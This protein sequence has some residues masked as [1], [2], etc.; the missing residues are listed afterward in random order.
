MV[1]RVP[2]P[3]V[4]GLRLVAPSRDSFARSGLL[5][6]AGGRFGCESLVTQVS[7]DAVAA[8]DGVA[9]APGASVAAAWGATLLQ[10]L[11]H[12]VTSAGFDVVSAD[13]IHAVSV[14]A[15]AD[16]AAGA[17]AKAVA[18]ALGAPAV[19]H[20]T[21][22]PVGPAAVYVALDAG[23][24]A[25]AAAAAAAPTAD[26]I[27]VAHGSAQGTCLALLATPA[28]HV[29]GSARMQLAQ[30]AAALARVV[31]EPH[32][33]FSP[34][35][36]PLEQRSLTNPQ[37][38]FLDTD[39]ADGHASERLED[40]F[41]R[42][43]HTIPDAVA[44]ECCTNLDGPTVVSW[45]YRELAKR[46]DAVCA[47]ISP[48]LTP[49]ADGDTVVALCM[50]KCM[51]MYAA[52]LGVLRAGATWCP[53]DTQWPAQRQAAL[54][55]KAGACAVLVSSADDVAGVAPEGVAVVP[56]DTTT[57]GRV[58]PSRAPPSAL[59]Y[60]IWTSGTTGLP[61]A[62]GI[63][64]T[65]AVQ[66]MRALQA[67][68]PHDG[69]TAPGALRF[70]QFAAYVFDL[71]IFD[72]FYAWGHSGTVCFAPAD[73]MI[74]QLERVAR[75]M[76]VTHTL[77]TPAVSAMVRRRAVP[78]MRVLIN[79]GE[80]LSQVVADEWTQACRLVNIYGPA[81]AT[82]SL[83]MRELPPDDEVKSHNIG[84]TFETALTA[85]VDEHG[86]V[87]ARGC[88]GE[89]L[90]GGP[91]LARGYIGDA[92]K[93]ADKFFVHDTLGR[94]YRTGDLA[95][96][97]WDGQ[98]EYLGR[99]DDQVKINGVRIEL[100]EINAAVKSVCA[101]VRDAD[102][103][104]LH[105]GDALRIVSFV[106][107]PGGTSLLRDDDE[108]AAVAREVRLGA[109][110]LLPSY[111][112]PGHICV[113]RAFPRT[114][115]AKID[116]RAVRAAFDALD[117]VAWE[118]RVAGDSDSGS[119]ALET[120]LGQAARREISTLLGIPAERIGA[121]VP[122]PAL[123]LNSIRAMR[124]SAALAAAGFTVSAADIVRHE[125]LAAIVDAAEHADE[126]AASRAAQLSARIAA[127]QAAHAAAVAAVVP[128]AAVL[129]ATPLQQSML[130]ETAL[131]SGRYWL[132]R[133]LELTGEPAVPLSDALTALCDAI[134]TLRTGFVGVDS[135]SDGGVDGAFGE[136]YVAAVWPS[137]SPPVIETTDAPEHAF[138]TLRPRLE[139][140]SGTP[141]F[142]ALHGPDYIAL[143][144]HHALYDAQSLDAIVARLDQ[145]LAGGA[146]DA[147]PPFSGALAAAM[148]LDAAAERETRAVW[149]TQLATYPKAHHIAFPVL[150]DDVH[151]GAASYERLSRAAS[152]PWE[153]VEAAAARLGTSVR[154]LAQLA[155]AR[156]L[157]AYM[158]TDAV[159]L[160]DV[161]SQRNRDAALDH[162]C[163]PLLATLAVPVDLRDNAP[164]GEA[165][166]RLASFHA[167][168]H[169]HA[170]VPLSH[171]RHVA[172][173]P[174][175]RPL[176]EALF[177]LE[178]DADAAPARS[179]LGRHSDHGVS[180]EHA[181]AL[182][183]RI[184]RGTLV[185][186]LNWHPSLVSHE[187]AD[188]VL[189][190]FDALLGAYVADSDTRVMAPLLPDA[191]LAE[192]ARVPAP[193]LRFVNVADWVAHWAASRPDDVALEVLDDV[194]PSHVDTLTY[195]QLEAASAAVAAALSARF[196]P[197]SVVAVDVA[198]STATYI[199]LVGVLR[200]G[201]VYLPLDESLPAARKQ[202]LVADSGAVCILSS[203][204]SSGTPP[205]LDIAALQAGGGGGSSSASSSASSSSVSVAPSDPAY[206]LYTSGS[207]GTPK[208]C[209]L[210]H[211]NLA[212]AIRNLHDALDAAAPGSFAGARYLARSAE[213]F[214]VHLAEAFI[215]IYAGA[216]VVTMPRVA[217]LADMAAAIRAARATHACVVPS[218]FFTNGRRI[219]P[220]DVPTLRALTIGG[221]KLPP[222][223]SALWADGPPMLNA[224]GPTEAAIGISTVRVHAGSRTSVIGRAFAGNQYIVL[225]DGRSRLAL[226][227]EPGELCI[228]GTHVGAGYV[229]RASDA[230]F[231]WRG[232]AAYATGDRARL[233]PSDSAEYL[234]RLGASQVKVRGARV[235]LDEIDAAARNASGLHVA[236]VLATHATHADARLVTFVARTALAAADV[237]Y[238]PALEAAARALHDALRSS[239]SS[240]MVPSAVIPVTN[241][242][243]AGVSAKTDRRA[244][245]A[246]YAHITPPVVEGPPP[247]TAAELALAEIVASVLPA[248]AHAKLD[249]DLGSAGLDSLAAVRIARALQRIG[250]AVAP[251]EVLA[252]P[253]LRG[254]GGA[255]VG[256]SGPSAA[257]AAA[258]SDA[259]LAR[260]EC[261]S[262]ARAAWP[263]VPL[264]AA[265]VAAALAS[266]SERLYVNH[267]RIPLGADADAT[268]AA[269]VAAL[270]RHDIYATVFRELDGRTVQVAVDAQIAATRVH[271]E[272]T[273]EARGATADDIIATLSTTPPVRVVQYDD[274]L[275][276]SIHHALYDAVSFAELA[277]L[278][279]PA[280]VQTPE[281]AP[282]YAQFALHV[283]ESLQASTS[284][285]ASELH[286][287][288]FVPF[289][290]VTGRLDRRAGGSM[291]EATHA[292]PLGAL[293][294]A[295]RAQR[296]TLH[297]AA[298][299][300]AAAV[301]QQY[302]GEPSPIGVV[303]S[304]RLLPD[305]ALG[306]V[307][308]PCVTTVP[309]S[310]VDGT[311]ADTAAWLT[312]ALR[313]QF[314]DIPAV[315]RTLER[316]GPLFDVLFSFQ[317]VH[318][319]SDLADEMRT[320]EPLAIEVAPSHDTL[321]VRVVAADDRLSAVQ[322]SLLARQVAAELERMLLDK[323]P[324]R[325]LLALAHVPPA[326]PSSDDAFLAQL[327]ARAAETPDAPALVFASSLAPLEQTTLTYAELERQSDDYARRLAT[328]PGR[329]LFV[330]LP[331]SLEFYITVVATWKARKIY[332]PLDPTL[333]AERLAYMIEVVAATNECA[334]LTAGSPPQFTGTT[335][336]LDALLASAP[337]D[338]LPAARDLALPA[339][340]L[341]TS[342]STGKPKGVQISQRA[343]AAALVS[344]REM[345]PFTPHSRI[346]QLASPG[347][348]VSLIELCMPLAFGYSM[349]SA[350][351]H[352]ILE[353][354]EHALRALRISVT[355]LPAALVSLVH[356][357]NVPPLEWILSGGD[358]ID[359]RVLQTW[360][361]KPNTLINAYG[362]TES[363]IGN[364][365]G[366]VDRD[367]RRSVVGKLYPTSSLYVL[368]IGSDVPVYAGAVGELV[369]GGPQVGD[370]YVGAPE[371]SDAKFPTLADGARVYRTGD[372]GRLLADGNIECL[373]RTERG[374]VKINGQRVELDEIAAELASE[375][376]VADA[377]VLYIQHP[378]LPTRQLVAYIA[379]A[380]TAPPAHGE[381]LQLRTD[382]EAR[383]AGAAA[384]HGAGARLAAYMIPA[385]TLVLD[386]ALPLTPNN[387][388]DITRLSAHFC[389]LEQSELR[390]L[391][392]SVEDDS[393]VGPRERVILDVLARFTGT[394][395][396][397]DDLFYTLGVDSL[398]AI[399]LVRELHAAGVPTSVNVLLERGTARRLAGTQ[400]DQ[401]TPRAYDEL[402]AYAKEHVY[403]PVRM[404]AGDVEVL[405]CTPLQEGMLAR[406][407]ASGGTEYMYR[408]A[409]HADAE[410]GAVAAAWRTLVAQNAILRTSF[411]FVDD[412]RVP[413][414]QAVH[415]DIEPDVHIVA[416]DE[417]ARAADKWLDDAVDRLA[418]P[419]H[420]LFLA[421]TSSTDMVL[422][423]HHALYDAHALGELLD[424]LDALL[425]HKEIAP[426]PPFATLLPSLVADDEAAAYWRT[427]LE[428]FVP[429]PLAR[430]ASD[431]RGVSASLTADVDIGTVVAACQRLGVSM[432]TL[433]TLAY[434][435]LLS[436]LTGSADV[437]F[438]Q[439]VSLRG[440][441]VGGERVLGPAINT[442]AT[443]V[444][445]G[446]AGAAQLAALQQATDGARQF[447]HA[448]L[449]A[450]R[451][452]AFDAL[453]DV[454]HIDADVQWNKLKLAADASDDA[455]V[456]YALNVAFVQRPDSLV[457]NGTALASFASAERLHAL[458]HRLSRI[459]EEIVTR[460]DQAYG[461]ADATEISAPTPQKSS[462][463]GKPSEP[464][465][466][467]QLETAQRV[468]EI[469][470]QVLALQ[471]A[472]DVHTPL[473]SVGL[474]SI[475]AIRV[476]M[477]ARALGL[478][479]QVHH[480]AASASAASVARALARRNTGGSPSSTGTVTQG[481]KAAAAAALGIAESQIE[482]V[483]ALTA[484]QA[485]QLALTTFSHGR[486]GTFSFA[487]R[488][489]SPD[490]DRLGA[491]WEWLQQRHELLRSVFAVVD[492]DGVQVV[493][494]GTMPLLTAETTDSVESAMN[495]TITARL[496]A[497]LQRPVAFADL[498]RGADGAV[499]LLSLHHCMYDAWS[500]PL[501]ISDLV[502]RYNGEDSGVFT[503]I[504]PVLVK[505]TAPQEL[506]REHWQS[507]AQAGACLLASNA[508]GA[509]DTFVQ[510]STPAANVE[511]AAKA[512]GVSVPEY[513]MAA[514]AHTLAARTQNNTPTFGVFHHGRNVAIDNV[515]QLAAPCLNLLPLAVGV[516]ASTADTAQS[517]R[518][519]LA[520]R[521]QL[522]QV[523]IAQVHE[524]LGLGQEPRFNT[525]L[526]IVLGQNSTEQSALDQVV[527]AGL[528]LLDEREQREIPA[529]W[530]D[531]AHCTCL[532]ESNVA[533][534]VRVESDT[535]ALALRCNENMLGK[536]EAAS[537][538]AEFAYAL[539]H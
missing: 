172:A 371:L 438:G 48:I 505:A 58:A 135:A 525:H 373:G 485:V 125:T 3:D 511:H 50:P 65:A 201:M 47:Q 311:A 97:L 40:Q 20:G 466:P 258:W 514:W 242:P 353:D 481:D 291:V 537:L 449:R 462:E 256:E 124:L 45:T 272:C 415:A 75:T 527:D 328:L 122:L 245:D 402:V 252:R 281:A 445:V 332:V 347:F 375:P 469:V 427:T 8:A 35:M 508:S 77:L 178:V 208:G 474:D 155:W 56:V 284:F 95:R 264:Q 102:T 143:C 86:R 317:P 494:R 39:T 133:A 44:L 536:Y 115:S 154:P 37:P 116:R 192:A 71:S 376:G 367:T 273:V 419:P 73:I 162:V 435:V 531:W 533:V 112:V 205:T 248:A 152:T 301:V 118:S 538:L 60:K 428:G 333:P 111:M 365:L 120:P 156:L 134:E 51:D 72:I 422:C 506:V 377:A 219:A 68:V 141:P 90:L 146:A 346:L 163:G 341:F 434:A 405:P 59:A 100:L 237:A 221:E 395:P 57:T 183:L 326:E 42:R 55:H 388:T 10:Y 496:N 129:P 325:E 52:I 339:F 167:H 119:A 14:S 400:H 225:A 455:N 262:G 87:V 279:K 81:E 203:A 278:A 360:G 214:D 187:Y 12:E 17:V 509:R 529:S 439:I 463:P 153:H 78:T 343:L 193:E 495:H 364:T 448:A 366:Y 181:L 196:A 61:K 416:H 465:S 468:A 306:D 458:L 244:L 518:A 447:R 387:K 323:Q 380:R 431:A 254:I 79:G 516:G 94:L 127:T 510:N 144:L 4:T 123:G 316:P 285:W 38:V 231:A 29:S 148:P 383:A 261:S 307:H 137:Y 342:G 217:L 454:Q 500:L 165:V 15:S 472:V 421:G 64:H 5:H 348:D 18:A 429:T 34:E 128:H 251:A 391:H 91:Q 9:G 289:P 378:T 406:T 488:L 471:D 475:A 524:A 414:A 433:A 379:C 67:A 530:R 105:V 49:N 234:G 270:S 403:T 7:V 80:K 27:L 161:V 171:I 389:S 96:Q 28:I 356:P 227:G 334:M 320:G 206:I 464:L 229:G 312:R 33:P 368:R 239:L 460:P 149:E 430:D 398:S 436:E 489:D 24:E 210:T 310:Y 490:A 99:N 189:R 420:A 452:D 315:C 318:A 222:D 382:G 502:A 483:L 228:V 396:G 394:Q 267:V 504:E 526:N 476:A 304:G 259:A 70:L 498:I 340:I 446:G 21:E 16:S 191:L 108:A 53:I 482:R 441:F 437:C 532:A 535:I 473:T 349:A 43:A 85:I 271:G 507:M 83:T 412:A 359:D 200:A 393:P 109:Q 354:L 480:L 352:L 282:R 36:L 357:D 280:A 386:H 423:M 260:L 336:M 497:S 265:M 329:A 369:F 350:P 275:C 493:T 220:A 41:F 249:T 6:D 484:G 106:V 426:R 322:A 218:L 202:L 204:A 159:L 132:C 450:V 199:A 300:A 444:R 515:D 381:P 313:H 397:R 232:C 110:R 521:A 384:V 292:V 330:H 147:S 89:L 327:A 126:H 461:R 443:R 266:P 175:E 174:S 19:P 158:D 409:L 113:L 240:Y 274:V 182:E 121:A 459:V 142:V 424:D 255:C 213:A 287:A 212:S 195:A 93:T 321:V 338:S 246:A 293:D 11:A 69:L 358:V 501:L 451:R 257:D 84:D 139:A 362:P 263:C 302:V 290:N 145:L 479:V 151:V 160:G 308:G 299:T 166:G 277:E 236:T 370:G 74:T 103:V 372:R 253:T 413:W 298:L 337:A 23:D 331:R 2:L 478:P 117:L 361:A 355:C 374:Q 114:S 268:T 512:A 286:N 467:A 296:T 499:L 209:I 98:I 30:C 534:D 238:E 492:G 457:L 62:V 425:S 54:L 198:R 179:V 522:E 13:G 22:S 276:V 233:S 523:S 487:Y 92:D 186:A 216:A 157:C 26:L 230:F 503:G 432:H 243:L 345:L 404:A 188:L 363:T 63:E 131:D 25:V 470:Q 177:V 390:A 407:L 528:A 247:T 224:Y 411:H 491:A 351:K 417:L 418:Q 164:V 82:L 197:H 477:R 314:V 184:E 235:E 211:E 194:P 453:L 456:Q 303:L 309:F 104:A 539:E 173:V 88:I 385:H 241:I 140:A 180:V 442:I 1:D 513:V 410:P 288:T 136:S 176:F 150:R 401:T 440:V 519:E 168:V 297:A 319:S 46:A 486:T 399:R 294:A 223:V 295:V 32:L 66:G 305:I 76:R 190:Q 408:H 392:P 107:L 226:R 207:T 215:P 520:A 185:L 517:V 170:A 344:W 31:H 324:A 250:R 169:E 269:W 335:V 130:L 101:A 283:H 138:A